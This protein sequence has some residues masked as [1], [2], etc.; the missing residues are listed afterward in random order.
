VAVAAAACFA[1]CCLQKDFDDDESLLSHVHL[2]RR[3]ASLHAR[4]T[5]TDAGLHQLAVLDTTINCL[6]VHASFAD[7]GS[8]NSLTEL[9]IEV[10]GRIRHWDSSMV[11]LGLRTLP[12]LIRMELYTNVSCLNAMIEGSRSRSVLAE[13]R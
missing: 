13:P 10:V 7:L 11:E 9:R 6:V 2:L 5:F 3:A 8:L 4:S 1:Y 12:E